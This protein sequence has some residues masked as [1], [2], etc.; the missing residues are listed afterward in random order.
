MLFTV[1]FAM[2]LAALSTTWRFAALGPPGAAL[3]TF[4]LTVLPA[5]VAVGMFFHFQRQRRDLSADPQSYFFRM[6]AL[7][8]TFRRASRITE[9]L[10]A[11]SYAAALFSGWSAIPEAAGLSR[12]A[13]PTGAVLFVPF[14]ISLVAVWVILHYAESAIGADSPTLAQ[15]L[16]FK[17]R[18]NVLT[19][20]VPVALILSL[21]D[22]FELLPSAVKDPLALPWVSGPLTLLLV[23]TGYTVAPMLLVRVWKTSQMAAGPTRSRLDDLCGRIGVG[24]RDIRIWETPGHFF[25]NAA[26]MGI[27]AKVRYIIVSRSLLE[28]MSPEQVE[29]IFA[30]ELG[31]AKR[32]HMIYYLLLAGDFMMLAVIFEMI[33]G[34]P[35]EAQ[36]SY[37]AVWIVFFALYWGAGFGYVSRAFERDADLFGAESAVDFGTFARAL[38]RIAHINAVSPH[39]RSWRHGSIASRIAFLEK[40]EHSDEVRQRFRWRLAFIKTFLISLA[41]VAL[42]TIAAMHALG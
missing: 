15:R 26:V 32:H 4:A 25:A 30:H 20:T 6:T 8:A 7:A 36:I 16:S 17:V 33:S 13:L 9:T 40:A 41:A 10:V 12:W 1:I 39:T 37:I 5:A 3:T 24:Y 2:I 19:V 28:T 11:A 35:I 42:A 23:L 27:A 34:A 14:L 22:I 18:H 21:Y 38:E 29:A 31:H